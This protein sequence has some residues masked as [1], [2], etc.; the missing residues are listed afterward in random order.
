MAT[1]RTPVC[2]AAQERQLHAL[3]RRQVGHLRVP[4]QCRSVSFMSFSGDRSDTCV[5]S[6]SVASASCPS[7]ATGRT[8]SCHRSTGTSASCPS[9]AT[10]RPPACNRSS[11]VSFMSFSGDRSATCHF[12]DRCRC[13]PATCSPV[14][15][16]TGEMSVTLSVTKLNSVTTPPS[17]LCV[18]LPS[19]PGIEFLQ[20]G[21]DGLHLFLGR[22]GGDLFAPCLESRLLFIHFLPELLGRFPVD[23]LPAS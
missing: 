21:G 18:T 8:P 19:K 23:R 16:R 2:I 22:H 4:A 6:Q 7:A 1:G 17:I 9:A 10:G 15:A 13:T 3:Q 14:N 5:W 12:P 20:L 11:T